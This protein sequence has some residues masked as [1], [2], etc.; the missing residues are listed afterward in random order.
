MLLGSFWSIVN[1]GSMI[2][3]LSSPHGL[4]LHLAPYPI[5][6]CHVSSVACGL[7]HVSFGFRGPYTR[8][9]IIIRVQGNSVGKSPDLQS[10]GCR[11]KS[12]CM[13]VRR[14]LQI[15]S[16]GSDP[17]GRKWR[18]QPLRIRITTRLLKIYL[19]LLDKSSQV[20]AG[21]V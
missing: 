5:C 12:H 3:S 11:F 18:Y 17:H 7:R 21:D 1:L 8:T 13:L 19:S 14:S 6:H 16:V 4:L 9:S 20:L 15:A 2:H 10:M